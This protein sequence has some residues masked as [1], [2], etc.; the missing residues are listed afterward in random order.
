MCRS[1][2]AP[3]T[4]AV[5]TYGLL[6][7]GEEAQC[8]FELQEIC[9]EIS[10]ELSGLGW[11]Q[12]HYMYAMQTDLATVGCCLACLRLSHDC[13]LGKVVTGLPGVFPYGHCVR[14]LQ[15]VPG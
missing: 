15:A 8:R 13:P 12:R 11:R 9:A 14:P 10:S 4:M 3:D 1:S 2:S 7:V 5:E 6:G